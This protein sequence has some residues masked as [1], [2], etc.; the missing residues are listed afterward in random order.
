MFRFKNFEKPTW[1][2]AYASLKLHKNSIF[3]ALVLYPLA[4]IIDCNMTLYSWHRPTDFIF[5]KEFNFSEV[6]FG[7]LLPDFGL[8]VS[9]IHFYNH[10][11]YKYIYW[12][13]FCLSICLD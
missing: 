4:F 13:P 7:K 9:E 2:C 3:K 8:G 11:N 1:V 12:I 10:L 5:I 6:S